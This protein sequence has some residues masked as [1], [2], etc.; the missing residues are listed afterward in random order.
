MS[1]SSAPS[2]DPITDTGGRDPFAVYQRLRTEAPVYHNPD[3]DFWALSRFEDVVAAERDTE[4]FI[5]GEG[6]QITGDD[7]D[8]PATLITID[9]PR[10]DQLRKLVARGFSARQIA[11]L[12]PRVRAAARTMIDA[13]APSGEVEFVQAMGAPLPILVISELLGIDEGD[14]DTFKGWS[15]ALVRLNPDEPA[16][17]DAA[18]RAVQAIMAYFTAVIER[19]RGEPGHDLVSLLLAAEIDDERLTD[20]DIIGFCFLLIVAGH[21]TTTNLLGNS[22]IALAQHP[23]QRTALARD[24]AMIP[25]AVEELL[26]WCGSVHQLGRTTATD[27]TMHGVTIPKGAK[28]ALV[29]AAANRDEHEFGPD[30]EHFNVTRQ[31]PRHLAFGHGIHYCIGAALA[32]LE[33]RVVLEEL[34]GRIPDWELADPEVTY[35]PSSAVRGPLH[36]R[37]T[38]TPSP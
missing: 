12:E 32:R 20:L 2:Y 34:L 19:R 24:P 26:R 36:L 21:E 29:W 7:A 1:P 37:L 33:A 10:H 16:T 38:F 23:E 6:I 4:R 18:Q 31:A 8:S 13:F 27:V 15:D 5:S 28:V 25:Q 3:R 35:A 9:N 14:R 17:L 11:S 30:A 22:V